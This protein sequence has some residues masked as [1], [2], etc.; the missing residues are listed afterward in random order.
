MQIRSW[1]RGIAMVAGFCAAA[2]G[3]QTPGQAAPD[4]TLTDV[5]GKSV[6]LSDFK[7]KFVVL[8]W[9]NPDCPFVRNHYRTGNMQGLQK[10]A[11]TDD[12]VWLTINSTKRSNGEY[13]TPAMMTEW[14]RTQ[15]AL[16]RSVLI[17]GESAVAR[18]YAVKTTPQMVVVEPGGRV[19]YAGAIDDRP[20]TRPDDPPAAHNYVQA[21]LKEGKSGVA[22]AKASTTP[23]GCSLKY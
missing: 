11:R 15:N 20:S 8:E 14:I 17:D 18:Q 12:V 19:I 13:K 21:A 23:Y 9:T 6:R 16:P 10:S 3:A 7:G 5:L 22:V 1:L 4:F 2:A